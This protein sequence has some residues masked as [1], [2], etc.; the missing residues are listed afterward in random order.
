MPLNLRA[1]LN[2]GV[3]RRELFGWA[4][5]DFANSAYT[6]IVITAVYSAYFVAGVCENASWGTLAWTSVLSLSYFLIIL[7]APAM[8]TFADQRGA[9]KQLL[10]WLTVG[11][12]LGT[13]GLML[14][15]PGTVVLAL[16]L[17]L[18]SNWCF[19]S[20]E[21]VTAAFLPEL[22]R[23]EAMGK[24][25]GWGWSL[26]YLGGLVALAACI[27]WVTLGP[28]SWAIP[29]TLAI[30]A[31]FF[32]LGSACT[33]TWLKERAVPHPGGPQG[34]GALVRDSLRQ[35]LL[36]LR[37]LKD[38]PE[39]RQLLWCILAYQAGIMT[40]ITLAAIYATQALG[41][42]TEQT[43]IMICV[44]NITAAVGAFAFGYVQDA[45]GHRLALTLCLI[46][47]ILT[48]V[49]LGIGTGATAFWIAANLAGLNLGAAQ[50]AG[51]A[52]VGYLAPPARTG[53]F[54]GL[55]GLSVKAAS[56]LGPLTYGVLSFASNNNHRLAML[57]TGVFFVVGLLILRTVDMGK[58]R[59]RVV[60]TGLD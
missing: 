45:L 17:V 47:W 41:F 38:W 9:K 55:W 40:I 36:S 48:I 57:A 58:G 13:L 26:G 18:V 10:F 33:F 59:A 12:I 22:A 16:L 32:V 27:A 34:F 5:Y 39:L 14:T 42:S 2:P 23:P 60:G 56:I 24:V 19:G 7:T 44:V 25:S 28:K 21:N 49:L 53:E 52:M 35:T 30:T 29:G 3:R 54:F 1:A 50:S 6:T 51:R 4:M 43:L 20:G 15:G 46:G 31:L 37:G 8:G 11:C